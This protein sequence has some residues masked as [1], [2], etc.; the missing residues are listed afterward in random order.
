MKLHRAAGLAVADLGGASDPFAVIEMGNQRLVTPTI[1]K[2]L[3]P[4][5]EK[6][7][8]MAISDIHDVIEITVFDEDRRGA[9]EFLGRVK[10]P[11]LSVRCKTASLSGG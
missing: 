8:E 3:N 10:I 5:W 7:Y 4:R 6:V 9:P 2:N 11:L 1:Y